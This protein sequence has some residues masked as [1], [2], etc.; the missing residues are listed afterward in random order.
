MKYYE[1]GAVVLGLAVGTVQADPVQWEVADGGNGHWYEAV[2]SKAHLSWHEASDLATERG[3]YLATPVTE[4]ENT[5]LFE[6][7]VDDPLL[8]S[9]VGYG[10]F[11]GGWQNTD[12]PDYSEP[13]G[14]WEWIS[15]ETWSYESWASN[16]PDNCCDGQEHLMYGGV[17]GTGT[18]QP[19]WY[20]VEYDNQNPG[21][22]HSYVVEW[23]HDPSIIQWRI[24]DGGNGHWYK[25]EHGNYTWQEAFDLATSAGGYLATLTSAEENEWV[26]EYAA[27]PEGWG[28]HLGGYQDLNAPD[29]SEPDGGWRWVTGEE[30]SFTS[31]PANQPDNANDQEHWLHFYGSASSTWNDNSAGHRNN[32]IIEF[33]TLPGSALGACCLDGLCITTAAADCSGNSGSWGGPNSSCTDFDCPANCSGDLNGDGEVDIADLLILLAFWGNCP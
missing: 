26:W 4:E 16:N 9:S 2:Y 15:G 14:G 19:T 5:W 25:I 20:D 32:F 30:W 1:L 31:W 12:S 17:Y 24:E 6:T 23:D 33:T 13:D 11:I 3:G 18:P 28:A 10:P 7:L 29:Y 21:H 8:F 27:N 22:F